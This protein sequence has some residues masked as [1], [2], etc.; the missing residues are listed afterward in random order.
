MSPTTTPVLPE[1]SAQ[2]Q[3]FL[4]S[5]SG[6]QSAMLDARAGSGKTFTLTQAAKRVHP[7]LALAF[8]KRNAEDLARKFPEVWHCKTMNGLGHAAWAR[9]ININRPNLQTRKLWELAKDGSLAAIPYRQKFDVIRLVEAAKA[10]GYFP[11]GVPEPAWQPEVNWASVLSLAFLEDDPAQQEWAEQLLRLSIASAFQGLIDFSDQIYMSVCYA[12]PFTQYHSLVVDEAQDLS[13]LQHKMALRSLR[14]AGRALIAGD[15]FQ[16]IYAWRGAEATSLYDLQKHFEAQ[17]FPLTIS[18]RCPKA[19]VQEAQRWVSDIEAHPNAPAGLVCGSFEQPLE[20]FLLSDLRQGLT[21]LCRNNAPL[22]RQFFRLLRRGVPS[23]ILGRDFLAGIKG[24][25]QRNAKGSVADTIAAIKE[26]T[27]SA[28]A[29][30]RAAE[31]DV[32]LE[33]LLDRE[34]AIITMAENISAKSVDDFLQQIEKLFT[35]TPAG[36]RVLLSTIHKSKGMEW[37]RVAILA[38]SL[39]RLS[40]AQEE[41]LVYVAIT[42]AQQELYYLHDKVEWQQG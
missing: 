1:L 25:I 24:Y 38:P 37:P 36:Q 14:P 42:R 15:A 41:N 35:D 13:V 7:G 18:Y 4:A 27:A 22:V 12:A 5:L 8:N 31:D 6:G 20:H 17:S 9:A 19:V 2:Q 34:A 30:A 16:A 11:S 10:I 26:D 29:I 3:T 28:C 21:I 40:R 23:T 33:R 32:K 39:F